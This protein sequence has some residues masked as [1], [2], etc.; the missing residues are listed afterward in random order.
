MTDRVVLGFDFGARRI[1]VAIANTITR[2][3]RPLTTV[4]AATVAARWD[5]VAALIAEWE[6]AQ[7]VVGIPR[8]PD[9][10][11]H[12]MTARCERFA[13]QLEGRFGRPVARVDERYTSAVSERADDV[14]AAA[15]ALILQQW[16]D[17]ERARDA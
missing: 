5:A 7:L 12:E 2:E 16:F 6:P 17:E 9:G 8:H 14:D 10:A 11:P 3:A 4:N 13:R 1:G 15:A